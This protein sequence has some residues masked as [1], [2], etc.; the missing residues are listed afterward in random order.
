MKFVAE[1]LNLSPAVAKRLEE[2]NLLRHAFIKHPFF[3]D[4]KDAFKLDRKIGEFEEGTLVA[5]TIDGLEVVR[6]YPK[7]KRALTLY[8]TI[9]KHFRGEVVLEEKMNGYNVRIVKFG[10]N[11]YA[12]T[13]GGFICPYTT[14]KAR[15]LMNIDFFKDHP[16]LMLCC[17]AVGEESPFVPKDVYEVK[18]I[19]FYVFD[20]RD[21]RTNEPLPIKQKEKLAEEFGFKLAPILAEVHVSKAHEVAMDVVKEL[22]KNGREGIVIKDPKMK[23]QPIKYTTSQSNCSDLSYAFRYFGEYGKDFMFSRIVRE[24][25]QSFEFCESEEEFKERCL[26]LGES[27]LRSMVESI[28]LV[29]EGK[30]VVDKMRL[31]FYDLEVFELFKEHVRKMGVYADFSE[32]KKDGNSYVVWFYRY[33]MSTTDKIDHILRGN[34]WQ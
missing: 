12:I 5:K 22:G 28:R 16:N 31:R 21:K 3:C 18:T 17:E 33:M 8:P 30:K 29:K 6:G 13:R 2:K 34:L 26:R 32:P 24:A 14:E 11:L 19:D 25:F 20:I 7:I 15:M 27:I 10:N 9:K 4:V 23:R 1:A